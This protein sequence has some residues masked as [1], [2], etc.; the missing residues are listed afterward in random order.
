MANVEQVPHV[1][2]V[3]VQAI[4]AQDNSRGGSLFFPKSLAFAGVNLSWAHCVA[5]LR[6]ER[7]CTSNV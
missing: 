6:G 1:V 5:C 4:S 7:F 3:A 2:I